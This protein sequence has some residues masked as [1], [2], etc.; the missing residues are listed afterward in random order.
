MAEMGSGAPLR[1]L[2]RRFPKGIGFSLGIR[3][4]VHQRKSQIFPRVVTA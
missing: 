2:V 4:N 3:Q 1:Y